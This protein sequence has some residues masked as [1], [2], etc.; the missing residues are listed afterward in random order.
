MGGYIKAKSIKCHYNFDPNCAFCHGDKNYRDKDGLPCYCGL[1]N[2]T[3]DEPEDV[4]MAIEAEPLFDGG[5]RV[6][7]KEVRQEEN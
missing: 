1:E 2:M 7:M 5:M 4:L 3:F 6:H